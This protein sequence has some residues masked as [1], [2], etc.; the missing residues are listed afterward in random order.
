MH[1]AS[2]VLRRA[3]LVAASFVAA[4]IPVLAHD[5]WIEPS[6]FLVA[7]GKP[8]SVRLRVG[9]DFLG[10]PVARDAAL[11][12]QFVVASDAGGV[13]PIAGAEGVD[14]AG[15]MRIGTSGLMILGYSSKPSAITLPA[16]KFN[17]Y[18]AEEGLEAITALRAKRNETGSVAREAFARCAKALL[19][20]GP[21]V[22][23]QKDR[24]LGFPL[25]LVAEKNPYALNA[26]ETLPV[27]LLYRNQP[28]S[29][30]LIVAVSK[31]NPLKKQSVRSDKNGR[32]TFQLGETGTWLI[33]SVHMIEAPSGTDIQWASFWA[34]LTFQLPEGASATPKG[35]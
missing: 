32:V 11:I 2:P 14:P 22:S 35:N 15:V 23:S 20:S 1:I 17:S 8:L 18:L 30:A 5:L 27:R 24:A 19:S 28:L 7:P 12:E 10:D 26:G 16:E 13:T 25:E 4:G 34:S 31:R 21:V 3:I 6:S 9:V 33:K 29:G